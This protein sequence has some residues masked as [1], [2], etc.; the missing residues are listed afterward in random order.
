MVSANYHENV[1]SNI[2]LALFEDSGWYKVNYYNGGHFR[3]GKNKGCEFFQKLS[4]IDEKE[5]F[6]E[7]CHKSKEPKYLFSHLWSGECYI[8]EYKEI[9]LKNINI[10]KKRI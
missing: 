5:S 9:F 1:I 2:T 3:F 8:G 7:F 6:S 10:L 4:V